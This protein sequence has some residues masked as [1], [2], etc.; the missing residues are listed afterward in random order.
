MISCERSSWVS[1]LPAARRASGGAGKRGEDVVVEEVGERPVADVVEEPGDPE[2][3]DD[4]ALATAARLAGAHASVAAQRRVERPRPQ[5]GLVHDA[6][7]VGEPRVLG[8]REDPAGAL[9]LADPAQA[10]EPGGVEE[11]LL[12]GVLVGQ[13][14]GARTRRRP[15][16]SSARRSRGSGR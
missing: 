6:E 7:A 1:R 13:P 12:G 3:L 9:E 8:G 14:G 11:V 15:G 4:Q 16:A 5:P 2:R 10:L